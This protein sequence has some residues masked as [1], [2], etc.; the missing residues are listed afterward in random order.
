[1][2]ESERYLNTKKDIEDIIRKSPLEW[3][4]VHSGKVLFW[5]L[6]LK[7]DADEILKVSALA[8]DMERG[9]TGISETTHLKDY[10]DIKQFKKEHAI[11]SANI[12]EELLNKHGY[13]KEEIKRARKLIENHE[14]GGDEETNTLRDADS[15]AFFDYNLEPTLNRNKLISLDAVERTKSKIKF[16]FDR[17]SPKAKQIIKSLNYPN[18]E[19]NK[20]ISELK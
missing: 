6:E 9:V 16:M 15:I 7:P 3:D 14:E 18:T 10:G 20:M 17:V 11:R 12:A 2:V 19:I 4:L 1:M 8:H 5:L 13:G